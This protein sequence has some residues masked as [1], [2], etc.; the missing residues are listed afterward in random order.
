MMNATVKRLSVA[1]AL[2]ASILLFGAG[3]RSSIFSRVK[4]DAKMEKPPVPSVSNAP[5]PA[6]RVTADPQ[7]LV[8]RV[9]F[10]PQIPKDDGPNYATC[11]DGVKMSVRAL[12]PLSRSS[13]DR[14]GAFN[15]GQTLWTVWCDGKTHTAMMFV[16]P[17]LIQRYVYVYDSYSMTRVPPRGTFRIEVVFTDAAGKE[18][19]RGYYG[20]PGNTTRQEEA[21]ERLLNRVVQSCVV[22]GAFFER[23]A[24][25]W[26]CMAPDQFDLVKPEWVKLPEAP[27]PPRGNGVVRNSR[28]GL[29][30]GGNPPPKDK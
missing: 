4:V 20:V 26:R 29:R 30:S 8:L 12:F 27:M 10:H 1:A 3:T 19:G 22:E 11:I 16:P 9:T 18:L 15:G 23:D 14:Y 21:F 2:T 17:Q 25:P 24:T 28:R 6:Q 5:H 13:S 7:W